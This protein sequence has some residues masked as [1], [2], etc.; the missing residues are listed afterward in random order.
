MLHDMIKKKKKTGKI[1]EKYL[2][3]I[4]FK[5]KHEVQPKFIHGNVHTS[6]FITQDR[7]LRSSVKRVML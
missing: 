3:G 2:I 7:K 4:E 1:I 5:K 6:L